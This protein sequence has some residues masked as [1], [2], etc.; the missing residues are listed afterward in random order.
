[1]LMLSGG[2]YWAQAE[3]VSE[4]P[5]TLTKVGPIHV[6]NGYPEWYKDSNGVRTQL[7]LDVLDP[8]CALDPAEIPDPTQP[9]SLATGNFPTE[10]FYQ[11]AGSEMETGSGGDAIA[12]FALE[13]AWA[14]E[15]VQDG[16]QIV[17]GRVRFRVEDLTI[18]QK[19]KI[20]HPYGVDE[21][22]AEDD[23]KGA[24]EI[25]FVE[26]IGI[27]GGFQGAL[28]SRIGT[29]LKW[30]PAVAPAAP[31]GFLGDPNVD[32]PI[33]GGMNNQNY[34]RIEG[35]GIG[36]GSPN[37]CK[38]EDG[39]NDNNCIQTNLFSVMGKLATNSGVD[40][41]QATY[42]R[43]SEAGGTI[44]V[45]ATTLNEDEDPQSI[46]VTGVSGNVET[47][48]SMIGDNGQ[49]FA[50]VSF[51]G[52]TA[53][54]IKVTNKGDKPPTSKEITPVDLVTGT[55]VYNTNDQTLTVTASSSDKVGP[56]VLT[57]EGYN[58]ALV[59]D[60]L[61]VG[62]VAIPNVTYTSPTITVTSSARGVATIPITV[63]GD[64]FT[65]AI[66]ANAG[67]EQ[68]VDKGIP[69]T[70]DGSASSGIIW[71]YSWNQLSGEPVELSNKDSK[72][73]TFTSPAV[74]G[75]LTFELTVTGP[76]GTSKSTVDITVGNP[77]PP[78]A[79][80]VANAGLDI[81]AA[82]NTDVTLDATK[83]TGETLTYSWKQVEF[84]GTKVT[85][86]NETTA[87]P[88]FT[89][90]NTYEVLVFELTVTDAKGRNDTDYVNV[91]VGENP[92][93]LPETTAVVNVASPEVNAGDEVTLDGTGSTGPIVS[94]NWEQVSGTTVTLTGENTKQLTFT[95]PN[96]TEALVFKLTVTSSEGTTSSSEVTVNVVYNP[97]TVVADAG[98]PQLGVKQNTVVKLDGKKSKGVKTYSW[99][100]VSGPTVNLMNANTAEPTFLAPKGAP[101]TF[102]FKL[103]VAGDGG[104]SE[105]NVMVT[106]AEDNLTISAAE[107]RS[108]KGEWRVE[109]TSDVFGPFVTIT[110]RAGSTTIGTA[111]VDTLGAWR[112]RGT[113]PAPGAGIGVLTVESSSGGSITSTFRSK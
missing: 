6:D 43:T 108:S 53:P 5:P 12:T 80:P 59:Y 51:T 74:D 76:K 11:L 88:T 110:I 38:N 8:R 45:Y 48:N 64:A 54:R 106:T 93:A 67:V 97:E 81:N 68:F 100:Q 111:Q 77:A 57:V 27:N 78:A 69:V 18:G 32:H 50:R 82:I 87:T 56:P 92:P 40:I 86:T 23:G 60:E 113:G 109:G 21:F 83:S 44:D 47:L 14:N 84:G 62:S 46:E 13:A 26:D 94:Y 33:I 89:T 101:A 107:Y 112:F 58:Q 71:S 91:S 25:R 72:I 7:C 55:A 42:S 36:A 15:I 103:L 35:P 31:E 17:F 1:M 98:N 16:D 79:A 4:L 65:T 10:A 102:E 9:I 28:K 30:D 2:I 39:S 20:T 52:A 70:L 90:P 75:V 49:Y 29:F 61:G 104:Q 19:Y 37:V 41:Q 66:L 3:V 99:I 24:G 85:L 22:I 96:S 105:A 34:F 73:A 95:A 63:T